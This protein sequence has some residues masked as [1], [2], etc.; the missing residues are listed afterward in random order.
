MNNANAAITTR[1]SSH[2][3]LAGKKMVKMGRNYPILFLVQV[4]LCATRIAYRDVLCR[5]CAKT[6]GMNPAEG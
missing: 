5:M 1:S 3:G 2:A 6:G 4:A